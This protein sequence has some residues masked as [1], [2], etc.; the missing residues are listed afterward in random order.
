MQTPVPSRRAILWG[1][2]LATLVLVPS[3]ASPVELV[4]I[5]DF[6]TRGVSRGKS[7]VARIAKTEE[8][9]RRMLS[10]ESF[11]VTRHA[12]TETAFTGAYW[13]F[14]SDGLFRCVCCDT[15]LFD[16]REQIRFR[17]W[18][19][20]FHAP[21]FC[22]ECR[23]EARHQLDDGTYGSRVQTLRRAF[24]PCVR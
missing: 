10:A 6:D 4:E 14:H 7:R 13:N 21:D 19:A 15:A 18:L 20:E 22:L 8:E 23:R 2:A 3:F 5:E 16:L 12:G 11:E 9:W 24:G 1:A 17:D